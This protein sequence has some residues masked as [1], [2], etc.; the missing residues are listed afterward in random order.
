MEAILITHRAELDFL[1]F[2]QEEEKEA[3]AVGMYDVGW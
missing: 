1:A 2:S 3:A